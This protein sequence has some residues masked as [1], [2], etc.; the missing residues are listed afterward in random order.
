VLLVD[1]S[2]PTSAITTI[3]VRGILN[4]YN[5][6]EQTDYPQNDITALT[7]YTLQQCVEACVLYNISQ[8]N[9]IC[10]GVAHSPHMKDLY[11]SV[12]GNCYLKKAFGDRRPELNDWTTVMLRA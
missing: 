12:T 2:C 3:S 11:N 7:A 6:T 5:C 8:N 1:S 10:L 9:K 4:S